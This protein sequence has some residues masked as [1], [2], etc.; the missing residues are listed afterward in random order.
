MKTTKL[1]RELV[2]KTAADPSKDV[3]LWDATLPGF[4]I[5][6]TPADSRV[7]VYQYRADGRSR[8]LTI[9]RLCDSLTIEQ[10]RKKAKDASADLLEGVDPHGEKVSRR[11]ALSV[12]D[13]LDKYLASADYSA[14]G[15][16]TQG[17]DRGRIE[18]HLRPLLGSTIADKL[19]PDQV[20]KARD[21]ITAG[22]TARAAV[23]TDK[24][25]GYSVVRGGEGAARKSVKLLRSIY[26]WAKG[27]GLVTINPA[28][29]VEVGQ[30]AEREVIIEGKQYSALFNALDDLEEKRQIAA[31][32]ADAIRLIAFTGARK[33]EAIG[34]RWR[35][36][37][38]KARRIVIDK[39]EHKTGKATGKPRIINITA[40]A[41][42]IID[43]QTKGKPDD[44][45]FTP[46]RGE[47]GI[48][49]R[50]P[51]RLARKTA[52]LPE[53]FVLH[54]LRHSVGSHLAMGGANL[55]ELKQALG[56]RSLQSVQRYIHFAEQ[57]S[58]ALAAKAAAPI[59]KA[60]AGRK[61]RRK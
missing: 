16:D 1:T 48:D 8:R 11:N 56:H 13:L 5:K 24:K 50:R 7:A 46:A 52:K 61:S 2:A 22:K 17:T 30:D 25:R 53:D 38:L 41:A 60:F 31:P 10:A 29:D 49:L 14:K 3:F 21:A 35:H 18:N 59:S 51:W 54:G 20:A 42:S 27:E 57:A 26:G 32:A 37:D 55:P 19:T 58:A 44:L 4:G 33:G 34:L 9:G 40:E 6:I 45:V 28:A 36:V 12:G 23:A 47:G 39:T 43:R 15:T